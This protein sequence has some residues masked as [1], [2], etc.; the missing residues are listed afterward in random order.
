ME[1]KKEIVFFAYAE[2]DKEHVT[3]LRRRI[4]LFFEK[5]QQST[6][7]PGG[8]LFYQKSSKF[9]NSRVITKKF[10]SNVE[11]DPGPL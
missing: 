7:N 5:L 3:E 10:N 6:N 1:S 4:K 8:T 9:L 11:G 2:L